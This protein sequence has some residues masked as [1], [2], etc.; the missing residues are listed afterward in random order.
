MKKRIANLLKADLVRHNLI[1]LVGTLAIS[2]FNYI[3]YPILGRIVSVPDFGEI[4]A[5]IAIFMQLGIVLT[6]F[7]YVITHLI[8]NAKSHKESNEL[9]RHLEQIMLIAS[10]LGLPV[11]VAIA[12][13]SRDSFKLHSIIPVILIG[14]LIIIN[15]PATSRS[16]VLQGLRQLREV[17]I[18]GIIYAIGKLILTVGLIYILTDSVVAAVLGYV[19][20]QILTLWYLQARVKGQYVSVLATFTL[21]KLHKLPKDQ[22]SLIRNELIYGV[23][24]AIILAGLTLLYSSDSILVRLFFDPHTLG[25]Y[26]GISSIARI[27]FFVTASVAGV[28]IASVRLDASPKDNHRILLRS[29]AMV[30]L[31]GASVVTA[32]AIAPDFF[33]KLLVG[34]KYVAGSPWLLPLSLMMFVC[35]LNNLLAI[36]QIAL[37]KYKTIFTILFGVVILIVGLLLYHDTVEHFI[38]VLLVSNVVVGMLLSIQIVLEKRGRVSG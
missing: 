25:I 31:L 27:V 38:S 24:I 2:V 11:L 1:F 9:I 35:S 37:R 18:A 26:S 36:Y 22:K 8:A 6:A 13:I 28:L 17:S 12:Y 14:I 23:V 7:G 10:V 30:G 16:Y 33:V 29:T 15:I 5:V 3:Y 21:V 32:F 34:A 19:V 4:Q 20:A